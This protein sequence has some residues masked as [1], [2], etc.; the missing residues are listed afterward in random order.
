MVTSF[1]LGH[2]AWQQAPLCGEPSHQPYVLNLFLYL[3][4]CGGGPDM[5]RLG[6]QELLLPFHRMDSR[7]RTQGF[8]HPV[9]LH[10]FWC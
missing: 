8:S 1:L 5:W 10:H 3:F 7:D 9:A 4:I 2:Q 6:L